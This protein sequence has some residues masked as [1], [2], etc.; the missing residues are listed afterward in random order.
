MS[1][2][3]SSPP[4]IGELVIA[5][6]SDYSE[7]HEPE[8][9]PTH[10]QTFDA[11]IEVEHIG[12]YWKD[13]PD[14]TFLHMPE[15]MSGPL[16]ESTLRELCKDD[17]RITPSGPVDLNPRKYGYYLPIASGVYRVRLEFWFHDCTP[18]DSMYPECDYGF[19]VKALER[20]Q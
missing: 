10:G 6:D 7:D 17:Y 5:D 19:Y 15:G 8:K 20:L 9:F 14:I 4:P 13:T 1:D 11:I 12:L 3:E 16:E 18:W 2:L